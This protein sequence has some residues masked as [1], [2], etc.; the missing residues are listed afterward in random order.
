MQVRK[1]GISVVFIYMIISFAALGTLIPFLIVLSGSFT[2]ESELITHGVSLWPRTFSTA[3]YN[4]LFA[5]ND[6]IIIG[7]RVTIIVTA[8]G[9]IISLFLTSTLAYVISIK[10]VKL[11]NF[12]SFFVYF[13]MLF[14]GGLV[15]WYIILVRY[16]GLNDSIWALILPMLITPFFVMLMR[17][18]F[19]GVPES[20]RE[21]ALIDGASEFRV[22]LQ[23]ILPV[24]KP[25]IATITLFYMLNYWN[26]WYHA[27]F[28]I[29]DRNLVPLQFNLYR[30]MANLNFLSSQSSIAQTGVQ[31]V[32]LPSQS[33]RM[34]TVILTIGPIIFIYP[35]IQKHFVKGILIGSVKE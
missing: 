15:P 33:V 11:R 30:I 7:Y 2:A 20:L 13:T 21:S 14:S 31:H 9:T 28:F 5:N 16:L 29:N 18:Y 35:F 25:I 1:F 22:L 19:K 12:I 17:T 4:F 34:A 8:I 6:S 32:I 27:L 24:S 3:G 26:D 10:T 23:I